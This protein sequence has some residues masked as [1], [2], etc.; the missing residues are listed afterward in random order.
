MIAQIQLE[1]ERRRGRWMLIA[2]L[3]LA[4]VCMVLFKDRWPEDVRGALIKFLDNGEGNA[5]N[6]DSD[7]DAFLNGHSSNK[8][9]NTDAMLQF[10]RDDPA[11]G[12]STAMSE[13]LNGKPPKQTSTSSSDS[14]MVSAN[15][16]EAAGGSG[17]SQSESSEQEEGETSYR[18][19]ARPP[20]KQAQIPKTL[21]VPEP[22]DEQKTLNKE[23]ALMEE[24][25]QHLDNLSKYLKWNLPYKS[26]RDVPFYWAVPLTGVSLVD[27]VLGKCYGLVQAADQA[28]HI[29]GHE[30]DKILNV[31]TEENGELYVNVDMGS[32][33][34]INRAKE[35]H[36]VTS[37]VPDVVRS[38]YFYET[39]ILFQGTAKY[40]KCFTMMRDPI[41]RAVDVFRKLK[42][43]STNPIF[44]SMTLEEY[45]KSSFIEENWMVRFL[46]NEMDGELENQHLELAQHVLGRKCLVGMTERFEESIGRFAKYYGWSN[47]VSKE[48]LTKCKE[49]SEVA[50]LVNDD[51][52]TTVNL[53]EE[54]S[55]DDY[56]EGTDLRKILAE[57]N[58]LDIE[59]YNYAKGLYHRQALYT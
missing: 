48:E 5:K 49:D 46:S 58:N 25:E 42:A 4:F 51:V 33:A 3:S 20:P 37:N 6:A 31:L 41:D 45:A 52:F 17:S 23:A 1:D 7:A 55:K 21:V 8:K 12:T 22:T 47:K 30:E 56:K 10:S 24:L 32:L 9:K 36:L 29:K 15:I 16:A 38:S 14:D 26:G 53:G 59:L 13:Y 40:G 39:A 19:K 44:Q 18:Y 43:S 27:Q 50:K 28:S 54:I 34:G 11:S 57:K 2:C 35:L